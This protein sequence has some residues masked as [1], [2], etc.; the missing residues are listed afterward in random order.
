VP[1]GTANILPLPIT[2]GQSSALSPFV[3][4]RK[5]A[6]SSS[7]CIPF[8]KPDKGLPNSLMI[9]LEATFNDPIEPIGLMRMQRSVE[10]ANEYMPAVAAT[11]GG[12]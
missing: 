8:L 9:I 12:I 3:V 7:S 2:L 10:G 6:L 1:V 5:Y 4:I 11:Q